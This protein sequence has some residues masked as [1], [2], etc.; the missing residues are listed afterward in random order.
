MKILGF[1][2]GQR[3]QN[4]FYLCCSVGE[5]QRQSMALGSGNSKGLFQSL[6][7]II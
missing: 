4:T 2:E 7:Y 5:D 6:A 3:V 1:G